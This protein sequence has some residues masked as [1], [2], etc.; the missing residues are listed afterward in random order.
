M[1]WNHRILAKE[2]KHL[3]GTT[4]IYFQIHEVYYD[5]KGTPNGYTENPVHVGGESIQDIQWTL[6]H[7]KE[8]MKKPI[9]WEGERFPKEFT[10]SVKL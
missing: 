2:Y 5:K 6:K 4:E 10:D 3:D 7:M 9:L 8:C 1:S